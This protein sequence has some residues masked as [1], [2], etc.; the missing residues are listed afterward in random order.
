[1]P[2]LLQKIAEMMNYTQEIMILG[3]VL[4]RTMPMVIQTPWLG[5]KLAPMEVKMG[6][7]LLF[8]IIIWPIARRSLSGP[9]PTTAIPF[10]LL[11]GKE[12]LIGFII[13]FINNLVFMVMEMAG[14]LIDTSRGT[15]MSEVLEPHSGQR[16]TPFGDL[17]YQLF[18][19]VFVVIGAHGIF[20]DAFFMSFSTLPLNVGLAP[21]ENMGQLADFVIRTTADVF[22]AAVLLASPIIAAVLVTDVVFGILNRV[23]PQL[24]AYFMA[25]PVKA[26]AGVMIAV[27]VLEA[28]TSRLSDFA[29]WSLSSIEKTLDFLVH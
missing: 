29:V 19:I 2:S 6:L 3:L 11:M 5:G 1:M 22:M 12:V 8:T 13:G 26:M 24:N 7:G 4:A 25:M 27:V 23:A 14:R 15:S 10:L 16:A 18:L 9:L 17:Y 21:P 20:F 28:F